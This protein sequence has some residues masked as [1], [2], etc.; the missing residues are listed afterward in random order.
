MMRCISQ[1]LV[2]PCASVLW[3]CVFVLID[4]AEVATSQSLRV[5]PLPVSEIATGSPMAISVNFTVSYSGGSVVAAKAARRYEAEIR[6]LG[7]VGAWFTN[8]GI[9]FFYSIRPYLSKP[10]P[11]SPSASLPLSLSPSVLPLPLLPP[12][13]RV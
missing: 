11:S 4:L 13:G 2:I 8:D 5:W 12:I 7:E 10:P 9:S 3:V 1:Q 6:K